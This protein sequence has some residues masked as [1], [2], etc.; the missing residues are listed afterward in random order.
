MR[1]SPLRLCVLHR[2]ISKDPPPEEPGSLFQGR[3]LPLERHYLLFQ[4]LEVWFAL[5]WSEVTAQ[6]Q[7]PKK[8]MDEPS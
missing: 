8:Q 2:D 5:S 6:F 7:C 3:L 1:I 4:T